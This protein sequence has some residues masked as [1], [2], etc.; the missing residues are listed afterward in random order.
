MSADTMDSAVT[1]ITHRERAAFYAI[2]YQD[3]ADWAFLRSFLTPD[4]ASILEIPCGA[5]RNAP[6]L[7][8]TGCRIVASDIEESMLDAVRARFPES[9]PPANLAARAADMRDF[10]FGEPF[11]LILCPREAIQ[12]MTDPADFIA[13]LS[14]FARNLAPGGRIVI[15]LAVFG[16]PLPAW[17]R[18]AS[19]LPVYYDPD[20]PD[21][22]EIEEFTRFVPGHG[23][24]TRFRRQWHS[25]GAD[26]AY[27]TLRYRISS[28][29]DGTAAREHISN[30]TFRNY[31]P[32][33][34]DRHAALAGL[35]TEAVY[36]NYEKRPYRD[37]D[38]RAIYVLRGK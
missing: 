38:C 26:L 36:G 34:V 28:T 13:A 17:Q 19:V 12:Q 31:L 7:S 6:W 1:T 25:A 8:Q 23:W 10:D 27:F 30:M 35:E 3:D 37:G 5:G 20:L 4:V 33:E 2:E 21:G 29:D 18:D 15:D 11:D 32:D 9:R 22:E 14:A 24:L 16:R